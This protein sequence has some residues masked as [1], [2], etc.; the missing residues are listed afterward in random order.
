M[1]YH[2]LD[3]SINPN[4]SNYPTSNVNTFSFD[5]I[6][7]GKKIRMDNQK[8][9]YLIYYQ[10]ERDELPKE[11]YIRLP[12]IRLLYSLANQKYSQVNI[13]IYPNWN[14]T[15]LFIE[16]M[17]NLEQD[18][19]GCFDS[20]ILNG[21]KEWS[22]LIKKKNYLNVIK[23]ILDSNVKLTSNI[24]NKTITLE[25]IKTNGEVDI[26][27]RINSI[28]VNST[29]FGLGSEIYQIKYRAPPSQLNIDFIDDYIQP[30]PI[31][32]I[33]PPPPLLPHL[34]LNYQS[35]YLLNNC[36]ESNISEPKNIQS[37]KNL[38][39]ELPPQIQHK[40]IPSIKD[41]QKA[42]KEL[43]PVIQKDDWI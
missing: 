34:F 39:I 24:E 33:P 5:D 3:F 2:L 32:N 28:W 8:S 35:K 38:N 1:S 29:N 10:S 11:I 42:I 6:I 25:D 30:S 15:N 20:K 40:I 41:L 7:I 27:I 23:C 4:S 9:R 43:K 21:K 26:V 13:P 37:I 16:F 18:I 17:K 14:Q 12:T 19:S 22:S 36:V 31:N